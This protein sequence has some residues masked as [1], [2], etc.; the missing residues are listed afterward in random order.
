MVDD[1]S[2]FV[3]EI[4]GNGCEFVEVVKEWVEVNLDCVDVWLGF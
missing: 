3:F 2:N 1:V 4:S